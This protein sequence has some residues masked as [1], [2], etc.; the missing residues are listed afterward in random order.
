MRNKLSSIWTVCLLGILILASARGP[1]VAWQKAPPAAS[2]VYLPII[3]LSGSQTLPTSTPTPTPTATA[4]ATAT[5]TPTEQ[6]GWLNY[7][8]QLRALGNLPAVTDNTDWSNGC[9]YHA[10]YMVKNDIIAHD[11]DSG[12]P[13][14]TPEGQAAAQNSNLMVS[15]STA[16]SD[17]SAVD[18]WLTGPFHGVGIIDS[19]LWEAGFG[20]YRE[21]D[22]GW[23]MG[24][25][26]DVLRG[27]GSTPP[28]ITFP[29]FWPANGATMPYLAYYG[30]ESPD[31]LT[32]CP[33]YAAPSG[34]PIYLQIG[35]GSQIPGVTAYSFLQG[36]TPL[37]LCVF[38]ETSYTN[39]NGQLQD[40]GRN[41]LGARDAIIIMPR[42]PL[43]SGT[44]YT[45]SITT[46]GQTYTWSFTTSL[47]LYSEPGPS[48]E[49]IR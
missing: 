23:Q 24:G 43:A 28:S 17:E 10:R 25:C 34:P 31:P 20:S 26:L 21:A 11:E 48:L 38:D 1:A 7:V 42:S 15:I 18:S 41:V 46:N 5:A 40:L 12:N 27:L 45:V 9:W 30:T 19:A 29:V 39:P 35:D 2:S 3:F 47:L 13:W 49:T 32:S 22:G 14:Y 33:G 4:T 36:S 44:Q 8:N 37:E 16:T 6:P